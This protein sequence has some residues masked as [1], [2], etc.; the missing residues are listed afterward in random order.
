L[1]LDTSGRTSLNLFPATPS[2]LAPGESI[3][4]H[5]R[6][7]SA[8]Y[9]ATLQ[10]PVESGRAFTRF[11]TTGAE[12]AIIIS[13]KLAARFWPGEDAVGKQVD[14][15]GGG[16]LRTVVGVVRDIHLRDLAGDDWPA[17]YLP[18]SQWWGWNT[19]TV[20]VR[21]D[22]PAESVA[23][24]VR[25]VMQEIAPAQ[26]IFDLRTVDNVVGAQLQPARLHA[27][28]LMIFGGL[29]LVLASVGIY[30]VM[31][32]RVAERRNEIGL[33]MALGAQVGHIL[34][35]V[36]GQ[37]VRLALLGLGTGLLAAIAVTRVLSSLLHDT[38][39]FAP[40]PYLATALLLGAA[41][42]LAS[43]LPARRAARIDPMTA[44]RAE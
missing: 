29:A 5:W 24:P 1:P 39:T 20:V 25:T 10:I 12:P 19:M 38:P 30:G 26:P 21:T 23:G 36:L 35:L 11:D 15:G 6:I 22:Q 31:A 44:L 33:R 13:E 2:A 43:S 32:A 8:D 4:A 18:V 37:G 34:R 40:L 41:A 14:P 28:L 9:F 7:V 3:Q 17:M 27:S 42:L 16:N